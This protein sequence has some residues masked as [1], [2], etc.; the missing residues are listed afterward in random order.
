[1]IMK[2]AIIIFSLFFSFSDAFCQ[3]GN[4][5]FNRVLNFT[6]GANYI[7]PQGKVLKIESLSVNVMTTIRVY[8]VGCDTFGYTGNN[9][10]YSIGQSYETPVQIGSI[11][12][13]SGQSSFLNINSNGNLIY[14]LGSW[15]TAGCN[16][17]PNPLDYTLNLVGHAI[18]MP[19]WLSEGEPVK[20]INYQSA[21]PGLS[22]YS[23]I[24]ISAIEFNV[25][26]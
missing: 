23:G 25:V 7:V 14:S 21:L 3:G 16:N 13:H 5:Q 19:I 2:L 11:K 1:M 15:G 26:P 10:Y 20:I 4:L 22:P 9:C 17:C 12:L 18:P 8:K 24:H 6:S